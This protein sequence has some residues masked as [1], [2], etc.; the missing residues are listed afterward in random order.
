MKPLQPVAA[1]LAAMLVSVSPSHAQSVAEFY[2]GKQLSMVI[3]SAPGGAYD[4]WAR[5]LARHMGKHIPGNPT[6]VPHN[7]PGAG[8]LV[9]ANHIYSVAPKD[10]T[11]IGGISREAPLAPL[12]GTTEARFDAQK[13]T[14]LGSP[15][16]ET[17][18]CVAHKRS[19]VHS[20]ADLQQKELIVGDTG[21]GTGTYVFP[22]VLN[23]ILGTKFKPITG[24]PGG[25][26]VFLAIEKTEV[27]GI[28]QSLDAIARR[29]ESGIKDGTYALLFQGGAEPHP[30]IKN[31]PFALDLAKTEEQKQALNFV[32][33][34]LGI[35]RPFLA[36]PD[37]PADRAR[38]LRAAFDATMKDPEFIEEAKK[39]TLE[40]EPVSGE[41]I[42]GILQKLYATPRPIVDRISRILQ[43]DKK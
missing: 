25:A 7:M 41:K 2:K 11:V 8:T 14:W 40:V 18:V 22:R 29:M 4:G 34:G 21:P 35:G 19:G 39:Q 38:A 3:G 9:A 31:V 1:A 43:A 26:Q 13:F 37:I 36:P 42:A 20:F 33:A 24:F 27:D 32:F 12:T 10:G 23:A 17:V 6:F 28:C 16:D 15:T 30:T 5:V